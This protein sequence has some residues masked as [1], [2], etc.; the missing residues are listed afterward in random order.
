MEIEMEGKVKDVLGAYKK[1]LNFHKTAG[2][3]K[4]HSSLVIEKFYKPRAKFF[5]IRFFYQLRVPRA[6]NNHQC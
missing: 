5:V 4:I 2:F 3:E 1:M 6:A